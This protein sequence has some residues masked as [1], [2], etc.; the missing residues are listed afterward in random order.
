MVLGGFAEDFAAFLE[1]TFAQEFWRGAGGGGGVSAS[2][3]GR[4]G[5]GG[6]ALSVDWL[7]AAPGPLGGG[8]DFWLGGRGLVCL[9]MLRSAWLPSSAN[10]LMRMER[11]STCFCSPV[12]QGRCGTCWVVGLL[13]GLSIFQMPDI[14][15]M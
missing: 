6:Y 8:A 9:R 4:E 5:P 14:S 7:S 1:T 13:S 12:A 2:P 3:G 10:Y 15:L 11:F